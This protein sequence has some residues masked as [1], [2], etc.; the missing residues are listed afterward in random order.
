MSKWAVLESK[1][2]ETVLKN[3]KAKTR[4]NKLLL[5]NL[6][7]ESK[8]DHLPSYARVLKAS[9]G[10]QLKVQL[11]DNLK[12]KTEVLLIKPIDNN[13]NPNNDEIIV[14][15]TRALGKIK[16]KLKVKNIR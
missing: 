13:E 10:V 9:T 11:I 15:V 1:L 8:V 4:I 2:I 3:E 16:S 5:E 14:K 12:Q 7:L 6:K